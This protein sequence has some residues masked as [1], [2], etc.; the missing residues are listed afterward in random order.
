MNA[1][2]MSVILPLDRE[3]DANPNFREVLFTGKR[4][5]LVAMSIPPGGEIGEEVHARVEQTLYFHAGVGEAVLDGKTS[6][7]KTGDVLIVTP[8]TRHNVINTG[9]THLKIATVYAP[10]N[11]I[12]GRIH[13]TKSEADAD[14]EDEAFGENVK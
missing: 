10:P 12:D 4:S 3:T 14:D 5:Q 6:P 11:H 7:I 13:R 9:A 2:R 8:G 1:S